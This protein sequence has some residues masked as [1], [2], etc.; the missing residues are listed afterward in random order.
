MESQLALAR[1]KTRVDPEIPPAARAYIQ[2]T[3]VIVRVK[4][5]IDESGNVAPME[6]TGS[7]A[8]LNNAVR[9]AIEKWKFNPIAD[10]TGPRCV[11]TEIPVVI[12]K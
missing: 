2:N 12:S 4:I 6:V 9:T 1:L 7:N 11:N 3:Q 10:R 8:M 5:R